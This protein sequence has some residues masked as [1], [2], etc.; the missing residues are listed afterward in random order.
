LNQL[1]KRKFV[2][3][4][5]LMVTLAVAL[6]ACG[7]SNTSGSGSGNPFDPANFNPSWLSANVNNDGHAPSTPT[8]TVKI[9][10]STDL[11]AALDPQGEYE[12][13]GYTV[14]RVFTRQLVSYA[15][16][17]NLTTSETVVPDVATAMPDVS[18]DGK[19]YTF[20]LRSGVMW[21]TTPARAVTAQDFVL[22]LK[23]N[24]DPTLAPNGNPGYYEATIAG[25]KAFCTPFLGA[26]PGESAAAR[27]AYINGN[28]ISGV[29]TPDS[30]TLVIKLTQP[31]TDFVNIMA[32][33]FASAAPVEDLN[34]VPLTPGNPLYADGPY[35]VSNYNVGHELDLT[36]N[37]AWKAS[38]DPIR[39]QYV[40]AIDIKL[41]LSGASADTQVQQDMQT[42]AADLAWNTVVPT[43]D[44]SG[45]SNP[46]NAQYGAFPSA[47]ITNPYLVFNVQSPNNGGA[48]GNVKVRQALEYA[49][50]KVAIGKIYG[51]AD[52]NQPLNQVLAPGAQG[53]QQFNDYPTPNNQGDPAKCKSLLAAAGYPNG[54]TL[55]DY[56]RDN[57]NHPA[58]Y[59]EVLSDFAKCGVTVKGTPIS[60]GYYGSSGIGVTAPDDLKKGNWDIT[61]PGWNP[62]WY[63]PTNARSIIPPLFDG[64]LSFPGSDWG[65]YDN[66]AVDTLIDSA[67]S[68]NSAS[69]AS[70]LWHQVDQK[71]MSDA[72]FIPFQTQ[73]TALFHSSRVHNALYNP[74]SS[75]YDLSQL[76]VS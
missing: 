53:Y 33:P 74:F 22:G 45:L 66:P 17:S 6:A 70:D 42:G 60:T 29:T 46:H 64:A 76:W 30:Q 49:I 68:A 54:L 75:S 11:S 35:Q 10:G 38:S 52:L 41:D 31:A 47:G 28:S 71:I 21:N 8:G 9:E 73:L 65:G 40:A 4:A 19:T 50:D 24:C 59:Q 62:D 48:L 58:V 39:H 51:G 34:Y 56:Y 5:A 72:P 37:P 2:S 7:S 43:S 32:L 55:K 1:L 18:S 27:A 13:I 63:G 16:S 15:A 3:P 67:L 36:P 20:H 14:E 44:I 57:G 61:E 12:T 26:D 69:Q 23:R 25:F